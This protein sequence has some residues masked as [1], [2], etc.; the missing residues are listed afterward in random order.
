VLEFN[1]ISLWQSKDIWE[2]QEEEIFKK[3]QKA[4]LDSW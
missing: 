1:V 3:R 2:F 4:Y